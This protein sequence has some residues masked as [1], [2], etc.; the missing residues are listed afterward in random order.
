MCVHAWACVCVCMSVWHVGECIYLCAHVEARS[1]YG[2]LPQSLSYLE[3]GS[4]TG[5]VA[6][7]LAKPGPCYIHLP[8][9]TGTRCHSPVPNLG[10]GDQIHVSCLWNKHLT[11]EPSPKSPKIVNSMFRDFTM[12]ECERQEVCYKMWIHMT[13]STSCVWSMYE[14]DS[15]YRRTLRLYKVMWHTA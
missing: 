7:E 15:H 3:T 2:C 1:Q 9:A 5:S 6:H 12:F 13:S 8:K 4:L 11:T 14:C 10:A